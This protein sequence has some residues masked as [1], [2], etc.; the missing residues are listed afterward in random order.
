MASYCSPKEQFGG[1]TSIRA[2]A[3]GAA[4]LPATAGP[5]F[6]PR[7]FQPGEWDVYTPTE[8]GFGRLQ[9]LVTDDSNPDSNVFGQRIESKF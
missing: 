1:R 7:I 2:P 4:S 3:F 8:R 6:T 9:M 5:V